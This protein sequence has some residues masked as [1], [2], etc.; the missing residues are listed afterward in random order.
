[1]IVGFVLPWCGS[2]VECSDLCGLAIK[3]FAFQVRVMRVSVGA[4][5]RGET[6]SPLSKW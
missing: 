6:Y 5:T 2:L 1:M 4:L 3:G